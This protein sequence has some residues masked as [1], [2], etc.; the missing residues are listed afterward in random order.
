MSRHLHLNAFVMGVGHHEAAWRLPRT[1]P[2]D[3]TSLQHYVHIAQV[4]EA[5]KLDS[6][7]LA[8]GLALGK[9]EHNAVGGLEPLT[10]LS[11]LAAVTS[12]IGLIATVST[13]YNEPFHVARKFAS[14]D[15]LSHGRAGW[16]LV[17][18][19]N[20]AEAANFGS[21]PHADHADR[22][23]RASEF[24]EVVNKL[25]DSWDP[26]AVLADQ[27]SGTYAD[28]RRIRDVE[29]RGER[30]AVQ[31]P[32]NTPRSPQGRPLLVQAGS[33][34][35][36]KD[37]AAR[38]A[39]AVFTAQQTLQEGQDFYA[40]LK[41]RVAL[42]GRD[43]DLVKVLPGICPIIGSTES[44]ARA[45]EAELQG[46]LVPTY[47]LA[48]LSQMLQV[49][50][51]TADLD[52]PLPPLPTEN[53]INGGKSRFT[54]VA[55]LAEREGLTV[56]EVIARLAGGRGHRVVVGTPEQVADS[57]QEWFDGGAADGFNV[58]PP[59]LPGGLEDFVE[60]VV[61]ELQ[62]RD[63]FRTDYPEGTLRERYGLPLPTPTAQ[64][65]SA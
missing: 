21:E 51:T 16:N 13:T 63:L 28:R 36:G 43:P 15:H 5:G 27:G 56:R 29:H 1:D 7:F 2:R 57:L 38:Y 35:T 47:G 53:D 4:A 58:M 42:V 61:P 54:L 19:A 9:V 65:I 26:D 6:L 60:H 59:Y 17:T 30:F 55:D 62:R 52:R 12:R 10:L 49:E 33:S 37:F 24:I 23:A 18:S 25:W 40:D 64:P 46:L 48:Q 39:E 3:V 50:L 14:L 32:L 44:E 11:A 31:G 8:D 20:P 34:A 41:R 22:Y 45:L